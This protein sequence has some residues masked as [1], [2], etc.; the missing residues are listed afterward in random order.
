MSMKNCPTPEGSMNEGK[1]MKIIRRVD[2]MP[3]SWPS[4]PSSARR[5]NIWT[6]G[7]EGEEGERKEEQEVGGPHLARLPPAGVRGPDVEQGRGGGPA[8]DGPAHGSGESPQLRSPASLYA[9]A[10]PGWSG[11]L[12]SR[13]ASFGSKSLNAGWTLRTAPTFLIRILVNS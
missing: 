11:T 12:A 7:R 13:T 4:T 10:A 8:A 2:E 5:Q 1:R 9:L 6:G 3:V